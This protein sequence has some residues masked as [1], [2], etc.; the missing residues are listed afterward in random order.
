LESGGGVGK[1]KCHEQP[2]FRSETLCFLNL[3]FRQFITQLARPARFVENRMGDHFLHKAIL[4]GN[5]LSVTNTAFP[6]PYNQRLDMIQSDFPE[7]VA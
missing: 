2:L 6:N 5:I 4:P 3:V 7:P 1:F